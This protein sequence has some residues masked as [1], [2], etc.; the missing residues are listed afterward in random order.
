MNS[1]QL[2]IKN[3]YFIDEK[4]DKANILKKIASICCDELS[5]FDN[6]DILFNKLVDRE[7][8]DT[9]GFGNQIAIPHTIINSFRQPIIIILKL[10]YPVEWNSLDNRP[11][12]FIISMLSPNNNEH[13]DAMGEIA[14]LLMNEII[15]EQLLNARNKNELLEII[16]NNINFENKIS[17]DDKQPINGQPFYLA[18]SA[19]TYGLAHTYLVEEKLKKYANDKD[20][21]IKVE[22][23]GTKGDLNIITDEDLEKASGVIIAVDRVIDISHIKH[24]NIIRVRTSDVLKNTDKI[25][26]GLN[27]E[28]RGK[29]FRNFF[30]ITIYKNFNYSSNIALSIMMFLGV[31][32][33][34]LIYISKWTNIE[35]YEN[36][37]KYSQAV[38]LLGPVILISRLLYIC[39]D[40]SLIIMGSSF[41][42]IGSITEYNFFEF[43]IKSIG[44]IAML[45]LFTLL[46]VMHKL[47]SFINN[48][49]FGRKKSI[50]SKG[51]QD[52]LKNLYEGFMWIYNILIPIAIMLLLCLCYKY[53]ANINYQF[54]N[55]IHN[56]NNKIWFR[57]FIT[58]IFIIG[59]LWDCGGPVNKWFLLISGILFYDSMA[60]DIRD[61][62]MTP[63]TATSIA[64]VLPVS[65][66]WIRGI[67]WRNRMSNEE[68]LATKEAN[69]CMLKS[70]SEGFIY[71]KEKYK[72]RAQLANFITAIFI[73]LL[74]SLFNLKF[75]GGLLN[76][77]GIIFSFSTTDTIGYPNIGFG[78][79]II[80]EILL[81]GLI[82]TIIYP[83][84]KSKS[85]K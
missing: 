8:K 83:P 13:I 75:Y 1:K 5:L 6:K 69:K 14:K 36:I 74:I 51:N 59:M 68:K 19:C 77:F 37:I 26:N 76:L 50:L 56:M 52:V 35:N 11:V 29:I 25:F 82:H 38:A 61:I 24:K 32:I 20:F 43:N 28:K 27:G 62:W 34:F 57:F 63:I 78:I 79:I 84:K 7:K 55:K 60:I 49:F 81:G 4:L 64:I 40:K 3:I 80:S 17:I 67:V 23:H 45:V 41:I 2:D 10:K 12:K 73:G 30:N 47:L 71:F 21:I 18:V 22:T 48:I 58:Y 44:T 72:L 15:I 9:T 53:I 54:Y 66:L 39:F 31:T 46:F 16:S 65:C 85:V 42:V 70:I 33:S